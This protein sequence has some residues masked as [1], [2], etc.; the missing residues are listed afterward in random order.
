[1]QGINKSKHVH[2]IDALLQMERLLREDKQANECLQQMVEYRA[3]LES[4][5][6]DYKRLV[7]VLAIHI[8]KYKALHGHIKI[9]HL[10]KKLK[11]LKK[12]IPIEKPA[13]LMLVENIRLAYG[14]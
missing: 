5:Y 2:L 3:E 1:M 12:E 4:M 10:G 8:S 9:Q 7:E 13:F 6:S 14:N 11:E